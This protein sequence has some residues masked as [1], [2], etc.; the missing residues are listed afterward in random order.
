VISTNTAVINQGT[1][2]PLAGSPAINAGDPDVIY[3]DLDL[4]RN[5]A[6][7]YGGSFSR[8]NFDDPVPTTAFIGFVNAPRRTQAALS[9][10]I[11]ADA[12]DR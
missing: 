4:S 8:D 2:I 5:D 1:G 6:G 11:S 10:P 12:I 3:A 9:V 7:C